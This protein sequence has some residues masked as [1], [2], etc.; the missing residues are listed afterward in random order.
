MA[1]VTNPDPAT[2]L[3]SKGMVKVWDDPSKHDTGS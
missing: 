2:M 1:K 3:H